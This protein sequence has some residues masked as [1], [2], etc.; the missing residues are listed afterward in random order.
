MTKSTFEQVRVAMS[1]CKTSNIRGYE[2]FAKAHGW[3]LMEVFEEMDRRGEALSYTEHH[4]RYN[5]FRI[6]SS[7]AIG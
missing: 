5:G 4:L 3:E 2:G 6:N 1:H 7:F